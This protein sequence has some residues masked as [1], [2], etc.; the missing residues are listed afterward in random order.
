MINVITDSAH[1]I[2]YD[3]IEQI[4][5][6]G[7][8]GEARLYYDVYGNK[9]AQVSYWNDG[10]VYVEETFNSDDY[11]FNWFSAQSRVKRE[12]NSIEA[13][14]ESLTNAINEYK[15][16]RNRNDTNHI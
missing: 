7:I 4:F 16:Y 1:S 13:F 2:R 3:V 12:Y 5:D 14:E 8:N 11:P 9:L 10:N 15:W 6:A